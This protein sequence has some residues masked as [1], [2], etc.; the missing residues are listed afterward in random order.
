MILAGKHMH[1]HC[2]ATALMLCFTAIASGHAIAGTTY[3][4][5]SSSSQ[6]EEIARTV[7]RIAQ[8]YHY[9]EEALN[10]NFSQ[11]MLLEY[12]DT[13]DPQHSYF[14][15]KDIAEVHKNF[16]DALSADLVTG[17]L[18]PAYSIYALY[19][20]RVQQ[21]IAYSLN[22]LSEKP[23]F[24]GKDSYLYKRSHAP[25]PTD[26]K[27]LDALWAKQVKNDALAIM[28]T[29]R[30]WDAA[31][32]TLKR[33]Y[34]LLLSKT[35]HTSKSKTLT[36]YLNAYMQ[37]LDPHSAYLSN[38]GAERFESQIS[39]R[40]GGIGARLGSR[41]GYITLEHILPGG[42]V[43]ETHL[44]KPGDRIIGIGQG[45]TGKIMNVIGSNPDAVSK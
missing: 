39:L 23:N 5:N 24:D 1:G 22:Q 36:L 37:T 27:A 30:T 25:F 45:E 44:L 2:M 43:D 16:D 28:L 29:G 4:P 40:F 10:K 19:N 31:A 35:A 3:A 13:L 34:N 42:A 17:K 12:I 8:R 33:R 9:P 26:R 6:R 7:V 15:R 38:L 20:T 32:S 14:T 11:R 21:R 41:N 18:N